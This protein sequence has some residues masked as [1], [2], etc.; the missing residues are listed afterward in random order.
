[1]LVGKM[2]TKMPTPYVE[3]TIDGG[4]Q[5]EWSVAERE[6]DIEILP[7]GE[8]G[9]LKVVSKT[10]IEEGPLELAKLEGLTDW[11]LFGR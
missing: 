6:L 4:V 3:A 1:M 7:D 2:A 11:L 8:I 10:P 9:Y 5:F